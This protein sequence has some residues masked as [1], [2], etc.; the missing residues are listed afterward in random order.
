MTQAPP[1]QL[2]FIGIGAQ[3]AGTTT[4]DA[5]L[6]TRAGIALP[7]GVKE[8][9]YFDRYHDR[10]P[11]WLAAQFNTSVHQLRGEITPAYFHDPVCIDKIASDFPEAKLLLILRAPVD[12]AV[13]NYY[14]YQK[15]NGTTPLADALKAD[16]RLIGRSQ[17][18][19]QLQ[20]L[21]ARVPRDTV[22]VIIMERLLANPVSELNRVLE[23]LGVDELF[24]DDFTLPHQ[25]EKAV[26][27][28]DT[29]G[30][31]VNRA[32]RFI[33]DRDLG[34]HIAPLARN[35][36]LRRLLFGQPAA[37]SDADR[38][39]LVDRLE[40]E[41]ARTEAILGQTIGEWR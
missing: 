12:R 7:H 22:H 4:L 32:K 25:N 5:A 36:T 26:Y 14:M 41:V 19:R 20:A 39:L 13:S 16:D 11:D 28:N 33:R 21:F 15:T 34:R 18:A 2:D 27:R 35:K 3:K 10:G 30:R 6:R 1:F 24:P 38:A 31:M 8:L 9:H 37:L 40:G 29:A 23:F 17:Y